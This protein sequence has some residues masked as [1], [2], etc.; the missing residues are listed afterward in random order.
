MSY[1]RKSLL[2]KH[3]NELLKS[4]LLFVD[5]GARGNLS[6]PFADIRKKLPKLLR[7]IAF[8][9]DSS[10]DLQIRSNLNGELIINKAAWSHA[11][12]LSLFLTKGNSASSVFRP[13]MEMKKLFQAEH[14]VI[15]DVARIE[16][17]EGIP[18]DD[19]MKSMSDVGGSFLKCDTQ[20][21]EFEVVSGAQIYLKNK[22]IGLTMECWMQPIYEGVRTVDEVIRSIMELDFEIF[23]VQVS[24]HWNRKINQNSLVRKKQV[25][26]LDF[27]AFK[28]LDSFFALNPTNEEIL[29]FVIFADLWGYA[30]YSLQ[31]LDHAQCTMNPELRNEVISKI[32]KVRKSRNFENKKFM[33]HRDLLRRSFKLCP[34]F[35]LIH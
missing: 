10:A 4:P 6:Q 32:L 1:K 25:V 13:N 35:P 7:V 27:L 20:G 19:L 22:C 23:D 26:G 2:F 31:I 24:A 17:V 8:E 30:D 5:I 11:E 33:F 34:R 3:G 9:P 16:E 21:S 15:R 14:M 12:K 18:L 28:K 29:R